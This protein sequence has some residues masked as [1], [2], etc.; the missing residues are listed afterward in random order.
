M[1]YA[2]YIQ[3]LLVFITSILSVISLLISPPPKS[4]DTAELLS[5]SVYTLVDAYLTGQG[6]DSEDGYYYT[7]GAISKFK[8]GGLAKIDMATGKMVQS[9]L[10]AIPDEFRQKNYDH[11]GDIAVQDGIIYAPVEDKA[12]EKPL[13][14]LYDAETLEYTGKYFELDAEYLPDGIPWVAVDENY[15]YS[16]A[17][18]Y[19]EKIAVFRLEDM[20]FSHTIDISPLPSGFTELQAGDCHDGKLYLNVGEVKDGKEPVYVVDL[21]TETTSFLFDRNKTGYDMEPEG[22]CVT[23]DE[24]GELIFHIADYDKLISTFIRTY[25]LK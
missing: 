23:E 3:P 22:L 13:V 7:S 6:L 21:E 18:N 1:F 24:N 8:I 12:E 19:P 20:K 2:K 16:C 5:N 4:T 14:L 10:F 11:I 17:N 25:K 15:L 9:N